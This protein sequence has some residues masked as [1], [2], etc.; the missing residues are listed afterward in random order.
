[1]VLG[2]ARG[3]PFPGILGGVVWWLGRVGGNP[4]NVHAARH[5]RWSKVRNEEYEWS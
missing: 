2:G 3:V 4:W 1:V 5:L